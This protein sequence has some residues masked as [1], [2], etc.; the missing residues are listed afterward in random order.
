MLI[1]IWYLQSSNSTVAS[2]NFTSNESQIKKLAFEIVIMTLE[3]S[4][5]FF[6]NFGSDERHPSQ[7]LISILP[8]WKCYRSLKT[9]LLTYSYC[10]VHMLLEEWISFVASF[11]SAFLNVFIL[12][13]KF[14]SFVDWRNRWQFWISKNLKWSPAFYSNFSKH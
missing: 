5:L 6:I 2:W 1:N 13:K 7:T 12:F 3:N 8:S 4:V 9:V 10:Y 14:K 11:Y